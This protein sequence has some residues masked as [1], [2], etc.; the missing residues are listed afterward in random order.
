AITAVR[1]VAYVHWGHINTAGYTYKSLD[2]RIYEERENLY[3][4]TGGEVGRY[5]VRSIWH[6]LTAPLPWRIESRATLL[7]VPELMLWY[8]LVLRTPIG[9]IAG[10]RRDPLVTCVLA[11]S[12][13]GGAVLVAVTG[14]NIGTLIR[15]RSLV[16]PFLVWLGAMG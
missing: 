12:V 16:I 7:V 6:Y 14:G 8:V 1:R 15:H 11:A 10:Y 2:P 3:N 4:M 9:F 5:F 13:V